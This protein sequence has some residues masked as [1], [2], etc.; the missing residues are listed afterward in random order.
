VVKSGKVK[1]Q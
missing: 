1:Y